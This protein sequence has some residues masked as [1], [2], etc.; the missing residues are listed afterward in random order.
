MKRKK[1]IKLILITLVAI[2]FFII[3]N[4]S[5][6]LN[7]SPSVKYIISPRM[8]TEKVEKT[9]EIFHQKTQ[10]STDEISFFS[11][12]NALLQ[13]SEKPLKFV[14][15]GHIYGNPYEEDLFHPATTLMTNV[16][17]INEFDLDMVVLLGDIVKESTEENLNHFSQ[18]F[19]SYFSVPVFNAVGN[20]D[21]ENRDLYIEKFGETNFSFTFKENLFI[22]LDTNIELFSLTDNQLDFIENTITDPLIR[23][24][25]KSIHIFAHHVFYFKTPSDTL[26][27]FYRSNVNY[28]MEKKVEDFILN[29]LVPLS[30]ETPVFI[31]TGDVGAWCGNLSP[32]YEKFKGS[33]VITVATGIGNCEEDSV[34]IVEEINDK[35]TIE[36]FSLVGKEMWPI[37]SYNDEYWKGQ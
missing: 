2:L 18:N 19:L 5:A 24:N 33:N 35:I 11:L 3:G 9:S 29:K 36:V 25:V 22:F 28:S 14:V 31:Y 20:H 13:D 32:Y 16:Q 23:K 26:S 17:L 8:N 6:Q 27:P 4:M 21:V 7:I 12:N 1:F 30:L 10:Y 15:A 37:E 34:L